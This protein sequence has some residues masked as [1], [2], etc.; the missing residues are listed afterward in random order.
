MK[1]FH[2]ALIRRSYAACSI[3]LAICCASGDSSARGED[4]GLAQRERTLN[5]VNRSA[6]QPCRHSDN[7]R[8]A[9]HQTRQLTRRPI[10]IAHRGSSGYRPEHTLAAYEL[11]IDQGADFIEPDLVMTRDGVLVARHENEISGTTDVARHPEFAD[12]QKTKVIDGRSVKG[13]FTEDFTLAELKTLWARERLPKIRPENTKFDGQFAVPTLSEIIALVQRKQ[14]ETG[15]II[16]I[17]PE[18]KHPTYFAEIGLP[19]EA[20]LV[21]VLE[22]T[23]Y[24]GSDAP[25]FIQSFEVGNLKKLRGMTDLP[26]VQ[27]LAGSGQPF[28]FQA[29]GNPLTYQ[30]LATPHGLAMISTYANAIGPDKSLLFATT[31][32]RDGSDFTRPTT[33]V[34]DA[35]AVGLK[36]HP[37]TFRADD[38]FLPPHLQTRPDGAAEE[39]AL[40]LALGIDGFFT[41]HPDL[42]IT[43]REA[44]GASRPPSARHSRMDLPNCDTVYGHRRSRRHR[45]RGRVPS[46]GK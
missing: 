44:H 39:L 12:R 28:D 23:G 34:A 26:L 37:Y 33:L 36:V 5:I 11:A 24:R 38:E 31:E 2:T 3:I 19:M 9:M 16:G 15:R 17:Y 45:H 35:H 4:S 21:R 27:L 46:S 18:T 20:A 25:V 13:W 14:R 40:Y 8:P 41:D 7:D 30:D 42:G 43:A 22:S 1:A 6:R 10:V 32:K 29:S